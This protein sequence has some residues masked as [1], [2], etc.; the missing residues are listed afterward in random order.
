[1][2]L[3]VLNET[4]LIALPQVEQAMAWLVQH[5]P[6]VAD[7]PIENWIMRRLVETHRVMRLRRSVYLA[8]TADARLPGVAAT[9]N[10]LDPDGYVSGLAALALHGLTD[11]DV[12]DWRSIS[13]RRQSD[14]AYGR[15][16]VHFIYSPSRARSG[17]RTTVRNAGDEV[18]LA[19]PAQAVLDTLRFLPGQIDWLWTARMLQ[20]ALA[21][22]SASTE[23][24]TSLLAD[25]PAP[26]A[27]V[28]RR[29]GFLFDALGVEAPAGLEAIS[30]ATHDWTVSR[31][32]RVVIDRW[33]LRSPYSLLE[34]QRGIRG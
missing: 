32:P 5:G 27:A 3:D 15:V 19:T 21:R 31:D 29:L 20:E 24:I 28:A 25:D 22:G 4:E 8:P 17:Q 1:M 16:A 9:A 7:P 11:Q 33:R 2:D 34:I 26:S 13:T 12:A 18:V 14:I 30:R 6:V 23:E 10:A